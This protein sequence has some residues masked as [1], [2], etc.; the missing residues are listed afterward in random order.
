MVTER[1]PRPGTTLVDGAGLRALRCAFGVLLACMPAGRSDPRHVPKRAYTLLRFQVACVYLFA[2]LHKLDADWF[3]R[4]EPMG[5]WLLHVQDRFGGPAW[6]DA[7]PVA[8]AA[9]WAGAAF[10]L[11]VPFLLM[12]RRT[13]AAAYGAVVLFHVATAVLF[14]IG[15]FPWAM[16]VAATVFLDPSWC[17][18]FLPVR[19]G[20]AP[21]PVRARPQRATWRA[22]AVLWCALQVLVPLMRRRATGCFRPRGAHRLGSRRQRVVECARGRRLRVARTANQASRED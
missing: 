12:W 8:L 19:R 1:A 6:L 5:T 10:D 9:S 17:R 4:G 20:E 2:G 22:A 18:R 11:A 3:V 21:D 15:I 13:R 16:I 7:H 14:P